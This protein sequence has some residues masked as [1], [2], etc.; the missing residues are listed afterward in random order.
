MLINPKP[1]F[2]RQIQE[3]EYEY[4]AELYDAKVYFND[5]QCGP[6]NHLMKVT[7]DNQELIMSLVGA[8]PTHVTLPKEWIVN[9]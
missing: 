4:Q 9:I 5:P 1:V 2:I 7:K 8:T 3:D 6:Y